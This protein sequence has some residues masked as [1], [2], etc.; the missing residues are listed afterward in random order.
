MFIIGAIIV[1]VITITAIHWQYKY[2][3]TGQT[4]KTIAIATAYTLFSFLFYEN[5]KLVFVATFFYVSISFWCMVVVA[6]SNN[7]LW[8]LESE[9]PYL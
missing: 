7:K 6:A 5:H 2:T 3:R 8:A 9:D 4:W 1:F